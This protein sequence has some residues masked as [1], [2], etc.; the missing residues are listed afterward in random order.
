MRKVPLEYFRAAKAGRFLGP[1]SV[2][3]VAQV[4]GRREHGDAIRVRP[5]VAC[6]LHLKGQV[7]SIA[8]S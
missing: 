6:D 3:R 2:L 5:L 1:A 8:M 4:V 7:G